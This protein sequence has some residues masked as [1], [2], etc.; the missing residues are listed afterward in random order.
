MLSIRNYEHLY[1][2]CNKF[3]FDW[4]CLTPDLHVV[5]DIY[6]YISKKFRM[7]CL[8]FF[9]QLI[10][11]SLI[12]TAFLL[13]NP[14]GTRLCWTCI[15]VL[16]LHVYCLQAWF[17]RTTPSAR[18]RTQCL[19]FFK[20]FV[21]IYI[22]WKNPQF[23]FQHMGMRLSVLFLFLL[24]CQCSLWFRWNSKCL[25]SVIPCSWVFFPAGCYFLQNFAVKSPTQ[26]KNNRKKY[27]EFCT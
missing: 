9:W 1:E 6:M 21:L 23:D 14:I 16:M 10:Q 27:L 19:K 12:C 8:S 25:T 22:Q 3:N 24:K 15:L 17:S 7:F 2:F 4:F 13:H 20:N 5:Y 11:C 26:K 18:W